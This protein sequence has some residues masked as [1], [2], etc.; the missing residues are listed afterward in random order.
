MKLKFI[1]IE[2]DYFDYKGKNY[3]KIIGRDE[4]GKR[5]CLIDNFEPSLWAIFKDKTSEKKI[6]QIQE[7]INKIKVSVHSRETKVEKTELHEKNFLS[8]K[9]K[10]LK[11]FVTNFKDAHAIADEIDFP[12][13]E[14]RREYDL[15]FSTK[16][17]I[18]RQFIPLSWYNIEAS[19]I[20][21]SKDFGGILKEL[22]V[23]LSL[24]INKIEKSNDKK[25][26]PKI[27]AFDIET[28]EFE[29]GKGEIVMIS[30]VSDNIKKVL[31]C[32]KSKTIPDYVEYFKSE[33]E[34]IEK[35]VEYTKKISPDF[36]V[37]YFSDGFDMPYLRA[38]ADYN[39]IKLNLGLDGSQPVFSRGRIPTC[40]ISGIVHIDLFR[41]IDTVYSQYLQSE[42]LGLNEVA[43]EIIG[44]GEKRVQIQAFV[45][46]M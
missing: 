10:A 33:K 42:T 5:V 43:N 28:D 38:R 3:A 24:K 32:K 37:G 17:I 41:F 27:L 2:Y 30:L 46:I 40:S 45:K 34:M 29:I 15:G 23:D 22:K 7:K 18:D 21:T 19:E 9:V 4:N 26:T 13:I 25:F 39:K 35:F 16:Y 1:P 8:K 12:E 20:N 14:F 11:I 44:E 36:I 6:K 31:T